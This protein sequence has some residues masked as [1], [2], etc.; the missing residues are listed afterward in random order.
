M[1]SNKINQYNNGKNDVYSANGKTSQEVIEQ[2]LHL[3]K[4]NHPYHNVLVIEKGQ[5]FWEESQI[6]DKVYD[7]E[8]TFITFNRKIILR[9]MVFGGGNITIFCATEDGEKWGFDFLF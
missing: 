4:K 2:L 9:I 1:A 6:I 3:L 5:G 8:Q 7:Q